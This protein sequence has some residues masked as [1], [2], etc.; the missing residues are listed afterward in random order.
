MAGCPAI[1]ARRC[2][3]TARRTP[4]RVAL[5]LLLGLLMA[6]AS[7]SSDTASAQNVTF[8]A[9]PK[10]PVRNPT[11]EGQMLVQAREINYDYANERVAAVGNVQIYYNGSVLEANKVIYDQKTKRL[12]AE[13]NARLTEPNGQVSYGEIM[14][15]SDDYRDGFVDSLRV[16]AAQQTSIAAARAERSG[17]NFS[18]FH[19][20]VY[21]ACEPCK[22]DPK[23][24]PLW[25]VKAARIIHDQG[26]KMLYFEQASLEFYG[27]PL[28]YLPY[29]S[30][31]DPTV[32]RKSG[33]LAPSFFSSDKI[34]A[35][36]AI[37]YF[38][39]LAPNYD[40]TLTPMFTTRQGP[41]L[42]AEWRQRTVD[43]AF[44]LRGSGIKQWDQG[45]FVHDDGTPTPGHREFRGS[46]ES[47]GQFNLSDKWGWGWD[48]VAP[49]DKT[50]FQDYNIN[51]LQTKDLIRNA[52]SEGISQLYLTGRGDRSYFD[53]RS[54]YFYGFSEFDIQGQIP[55]IHPVID[56]SYTFGQ[57]VL[58]GELSYRMN[59]TSLSRE[60]ASF[61][62]ITQAAVNHDFCAPSADPARTIPGNCVLRG[63]P[64]IYSRLSAET[65][66]RRSI[67]DPL[68][69]VFTPF[70]YARGDVASL[71]ID[72]TAAV[73]NFL[74]EGDT[75]LVRAMPAAGLEYRYP[76]IGVQSWGTQTIEPI[77]QIIVRPNETGVGRLPNEDAQSLIFDDSNLFKLDKFSGW[78]RQE[79]GTRAN[80]G[81]QYTAQVNNAGF[82]NVLFGQSYQLMGENSFTQGGVTNTGLDSG[83][84][85]PRSDYVARF[86]YQPSRMYAFTSRFRFDEETW[87]VKRFE[88][89]SRVNLDRWSFTGIYGRYAAQPELGFLTDREGVLGT[90]SLRLTS[91]W[92]IFGAIGYDLDQHR[93]DQTQLGVTY[94]DDCIALALQYTTSYSY[95]GNPQEKTHAIMMTLALRTLWD[96]QISQSVSGV[97]G[98]F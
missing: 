54:M 89:E 2:R 70:L 78:D 33:F 7:L 63:F 37:P 64:G 9:R 29:F 86:A 39:A 97:P 47:S 84:D 94:I 24:P 20:G 26:E 77:A 35:A 6:E 72:P 8:P 92:S 1:C 28:V 46:F 87:D 65:T 11:T 58:G 69:Q 31:P 32:K 98:G 61:D 25:Q 60:Q 50:F 55:I 27:K 82:F 13:G 88:V 74:P 68:G 96:G 51:R 41:L 90:S 75:N 71:S 44:L 40:L 83:L 36:V 52:P 21:T 38:W 62:A 76:F 14:E 5:L 91:N 73:D 95:S 30:A 12:R 56:Y 18:I 85:K 67:T 19:S 49:S 59:L 66:W 22:D 16:D 45:Y 93:V 53:A 34:G 10:P 79:G 17:G 15:L 3:L 23:K 42:E 48:I 81:V 4:W 80:V 43:G 57:P